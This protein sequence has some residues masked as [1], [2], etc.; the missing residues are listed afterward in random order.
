VKDSLLE[1]VESFNAPRVQYQSKLVAGFVAQI[2]LEVAP[3]AAIE[4]PASKNSNP[5]R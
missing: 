5:M 3:I 4:K 1:A 2:S